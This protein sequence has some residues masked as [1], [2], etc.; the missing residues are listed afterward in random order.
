MSPGRAPVYL[1]RGEVICSLGTN[2]AAVE[3]RLFG[4][5][6]ENGFLTLSDR[7][8]PGR[9][10]P[11]GLVAE[12]LPAAAIDGED[13]RNNRMLAAAVTP[14]LAAIDDLKARFGRRRIGI[15]IGTS[16]SGIAEGEA[17]LGCDGGAPLLAPGYRY[18]SQELSATTR[19]LSRWLD[20]AGP[21]WTLSSACTSG[22]KALAS[23]TRLL[24][25]GA[26]D[27]VIAGGVDTLCR[28]TLAGFSSLM[29]TAD[30]VCNPFSDNRRGINIGEGAA[31]F[32]VSREPGPVRLAGIGESSD[33][34]HISSPDPEGRGAE[35]AIRQALATAGLAPEQ[36][37]YINLHGTA[38]AQNDLME[39]IAVNRV[40][41]AS[42]ACSSTK[43]L[44][45]HTLA[46]AGAIEALLCWLLLQRRD[47]R[48]PPHLWDGHRDPEIPA[49]D[50][51]GRARLGRPVNT[52]MSNS[53]AFGGNNLSLVMTRETGL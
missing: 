16:T 4:T 13:T 53:F 10:L 35:A 19:F 40:F 14:L 7:Y 36:I 37:D 6:P 8:S 1:N 38:T 39:G 2:L 44:T 20:I 42:V 47:D 49:L 51:L 29:V 43:P 34:Y 48:L 22:G 23:A 46:A 17:A 33:A 52:V 30:T 32:V 12:E 26:C 31:V 25:L 3:S 18:T 28:M 9:P 45:G 27:A 5:E 11:L 24:N 15:V 41:G 50:G 21:C